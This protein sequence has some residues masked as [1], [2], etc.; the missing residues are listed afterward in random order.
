M[1]NYISTGISHLD[2]LLGGKGFDAESVI[3]LRGEPGTG[4]TTLAFQI[5]KS[6]RESG[7]KFGSDEYHIVFVC[8]ENLADIALSKIISSFWQHTYPDYSTFVN[9][10]GSWKSVDLNE[11]IDA[12][13]AIDRQSKPAGEF[14]D[15]N[16]DKLLTD[17]W[18]SIV[19]KIDKPMVIIIDSL[20]AMIYAAQH[21]FRNYDDRK[22]LL[23]IFNSFHS[24]WTNQAL[25]PTVLFTAEDTRGAVSRNAE[26]YIADIVIELRRETTEYTIHLTPDETESWKE[27]LSFC[28]VIKGRGLRIQKIP[29]CYEFV[30]DKGIEFFPTYAAQGFVSLYFENSPQL[31]VIHNIRLLDFPLSYPGV[32]VQEFTRP[33]LQR[34]FSVRRYQNRIPPRHPMLVSH[35]DEYWV[36]VLKKASLLY[37]IPKNRLKLFS[38]SDGEDNNTS[39]IREISDKKESIYLE[40]DSYL[41]VPQMGNVGMLVYRKDI[42]NDLGIKSPPATWEEIEEICTDLRQ[43]N[44][45]ERQFLIETRTYDTLLIT[46]LEFGWSFGSFW[47]TY[48][49]QDNKIRVYFKDN[50]TYDKF[51]DAI[52]LIRDW[53]H[54]KYIIPKNSSVDPEYHSKADWVFARHW[55]STWVDVITKP[56]LHGVKLIDNPEFSELY[57]VAPLPI[58]KEYRRAQS[59][60]GQ[61][62]QH[63]SGMG[64]WY[65][66]IQSNSENF[67]LGLD[68][69]N[70]LMT[71]RKVT[72]RALGGVELPVI[73]KFYELYGEAICFG[74]NKT[75]NEIRK[76]FFPNAK[77]RTMFSEYRPL[78]RVLYGA[79]RAVVSNGNVEVK[80]L[81]NKAFSEL[82]NGFK[83][84]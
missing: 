79:L 49:E 19:G 46:A 52:T 17:L 47:N 24:W 70:N 32:V 34:M 69:I 83:I 44:K 84:N 41:A 5:A 61:P 1:R 56:D 28:Q 66:M 7:L 26:S 80:S 30:R 67:E 4:K 33:Y 22:M 12:W 37:P 3:L 15:D 13:V 2:N 75:Y 55:Y 78:A 62:I 18:K 59:E 57:D 82:D 65:L 53:I 73:E 77:S 8:I 45:K 21:H 74:T 43:K 40:N 36:D 39:I 23:A 14:R 9:R 20:D 25:K 63:H 60:A 58:S 68:I 42:L 16:L 81:L 54:K 10:I 11:L 48:L 29:L 71:S 76:E 72:E 64:E 51:V 31:E 50:D 38:L 27:N 6:I 35:V